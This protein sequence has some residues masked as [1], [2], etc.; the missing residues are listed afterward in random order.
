MPDPSLLENAEVC[1]CSNSAQRQPLNFA[2]FLST[3]HKRGADQATVR[4]LMK[5][6]LLR[7][8]FKRLA[9]AWV[10][11]PHPMRQLGQNGIKQTS[12]SSGQ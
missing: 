7:D 10:N 4:K 2:A 1:R 11:F 12:L 6:R 5:K 3:C 8:Q 9:K